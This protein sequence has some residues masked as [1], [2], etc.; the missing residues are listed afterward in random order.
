MKISPA[1]IISF[2]CAMLSSLLVACLCAYQGGFVKLEVWKS[3]I[4]ATA[5]FIVVYLSCYILLRTLVF[6]KIKVI[7]E[8]ISELSER[9]GNKNTTVDLDKMKEK[10]TAFSLR[11]GEEIERLK[12]LEQYR[13][14]FLG[15]VSHELKTPIFNIQGYLETLID[16][17]LDDRKISESY[18]LKAS[19]NAERLNDIVS[20]LL[21]ISQYE[22]GALKLDVE[23]YD[24]RA[25]LAEILDTFQLQAGTKSIQLRFRENYEGPFYVEAD[26][27]R[28]GQVINNLVSNAIKY[29]NEGGYVSVALAEHNDTVLVE[30]SDNGP[31]IAQEYI[32]RLFER[33]FRID[34]A[35]SREQGGTGLGLAIVK[36][37][38]E[39]H[40]QTI[41]VQST[42][43]IGTTF[44]FS[45][46]KG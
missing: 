18:I 29:N 31:G 13:K 12:K 15:N 22:S 32:G 37:I 9:N 40:K 38:I 21:S 24:V 43:G 45:L 10:V 11:K 46:K 5:V 7:G 3:S 2:F 35:R 23:T 34:K 28:V 1:H 8:M 41:T 26:K 14:E 4:L 36:H 27:M 33:F 44:T 17:G 42:V 16:G 6:E 30:V 25:Q 39:A 20:D 19:Q